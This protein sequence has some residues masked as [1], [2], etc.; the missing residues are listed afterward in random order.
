MS[1]LYSIVWAKRALCPRQF[2]WYAG[3]L[4]KSACQRSKMNKD[5]LK[6][7]ETCSFAA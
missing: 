4:T 7:E 3:S 1:G 2:G 5:V 6:Q